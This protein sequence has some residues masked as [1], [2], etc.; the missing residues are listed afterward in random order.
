MTD[1]QGKLLCYVLD[2]SQEMIISFDEQGYVNHANDRTCELTGYSYEELQGM[3]IGELYKEVFRVVGSEIKLVEGYHREEQIDTFIYRKNKTCFPVSLNVLG[4]LKLNS[5]KKV[6]FS[7]AINMTRQKINMRRL[8]ETTEQLRAAMKDRDSFVANVTHELRTPVNGIKGHTEIMLEDET[9]SQKRNYLK[10]ILDCCST[11]EGIINNI[12]DFSKLEA[13]RFQI[14]EHAFSFHE[15]L[16][17]RQE[18]FGAFALRKGLR[19][20]MNVAPD[21]PQTL[22]GDELRLTQI[23]NNLVSNAVK[24][25]SQGYVGIEVMKNMQIGNEIEL[26]FMVV[27]TGIGLAPEDKEKLFTSFSQADASITR[28]YGGTGLGLAITKELVQMMGGSIHAEGERGKGSNFSF[29]IRMKTEEE[30]QEPSPEVLNW[31]P[32]QMFSQLEKEQDLMNE[33]GSEINA[34]EIQGNFEKLNLSMDLGNWQKA[35]GYMDALKQ[36][37][38]GGSKKLQKT[39]F[40]LG[41]AVRKADYEK[42]KEAEKNVIDVLR[43]DWKELN[44]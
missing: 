34:R 5:G 12:L 2:N 16:E 35:E 4:P 33:F 32:A 24:F 15:F 20:V 28:K 10:M 37:T 14:E 9:D 1:E 42:A 19:F 21:I 43:Q 7:M 8:E 27:D 22:I 31:N 29:T 11:M 13:G 39:A 40:R 23:L 26:F 36:L 38:Q 41:M 30:V 44:S 25:T 17:K 18:Q 3:F 6:L